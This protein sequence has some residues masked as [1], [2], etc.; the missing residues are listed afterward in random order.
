MAASGR[1]V[2]VA[3]GRLL[4]GKRLSGFP[5]LDIQLEKPERR[6]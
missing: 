5:I 1:R 3:V 4:A 6:R 2:Q